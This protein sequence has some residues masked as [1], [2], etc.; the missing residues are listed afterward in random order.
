MAKSTV[1]KK[2]QKRKAKQK[3]VKTLNVQKTTREKGWL[4]LEDARYFCDTGDMD[5]AV[6]F[7]KRASSALPREEQVF[8]LMGYIGS[9]TGNTALELDAF[10][11]L[12]RIGKITDE[13]QIDRLFKLFP[14]ERYK[15]CCEQ[16]EQ[17]LETFPQLRIRNKKKIK[18]KIQALRESCRV[19]IAH[20]E[21]IKNK[22]TKAVVSKPPHQRTQ[23]LEKTRP[24]KKRD[25]KDKP[26]IPAESHQ[27][28]VP[29]VPITWKIEDHC[30]F[31]ALSDPL[32]A[33]PETYEMA[34]QSHG[35]RFV[36]SFE[37]LIC[38]SSLTAVK[39]YWY[40]EETAKKVLKQFRG[41][42]LLSDEV[43]LGKTIEALMILA[44]YIKRGMVKT[45]LIL[46]PNPLVSQWQQEM[47]SKF[48]MDVSSTD[49]PEFK[50]GSQNFWK[51][52]F[53]I[54]SINQAKSKK[55]VDL[56]TAREYDL[57]I[58][59]EAH[60]LKNR[61][62]LNWKLVNSLKK[63]FI[64]LLT[65]TPVENNLMELYNLITLLKPGQLETATAF[66]EKFMKRGDPTD[67]RNRVLL[68][69]L[70]GQV[71]IRNTR[72]VA[73][74]NIPPRFAQTIRIAPTK[75]EK[76]FYARLEDL[77]MSLNEK[78]AGRAKLI[79][80]NLLAQ[81]GSSPK[82][83]ELTL[84]RML[85][86][87]DYL[88]AHEQELRAVKNLCRTLLDTPK[89]KALLKIITV[90]REKIIVFAKYKGTIE[91]LVDFLDWNGISFSVFHG[92][93]NNQQKDDAIQAFKDKAQVLVTT[94]IGGEGR[95]LQFCSRMV[96]YDLP[97]N[98]MKIEQRI[99]RI[100]RIG[101]EKEVQI[102]NFCATGSIEDYIL[103]I[104][105]RKINMFEM[106]IGE[107]D[108]IIGRIRGEAEFSDRV[109]DIWMNST[110]EQDRK[111]S[112][113]NL[114]ASLKRAKTGYDK[115]REL[116]EKLFGDGYE[117]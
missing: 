75:T 29:D 17:V 6:K 53:I 94:E 15:E 11:G 14:L 24:L 101:Q 47:K 65:A 73:G 18:A 55:N 104:L 7:I 112:F 45:C 35:I 103:D 4:F 50:S 12:D 74:I 92:S 88:L 56:I 77:I 9:C 10:S 3:Q 98:P 67:P 46:T 109:L 78:K 89:N 41:R 72:A 83:V 37:T 85:E 2:K 36:E 32:P 96:N 40:Q 86:K 114:G 111:K 42:A 16:A 23:K 70:L 117:L 115:T 27:S 25:R 8:H 49:D 64:L 19:L 62:T 95:N 81:A 20:E 69:E 54:A 71:M 63:R 22:K 87:E 102:F 51:A 1:D 28:V 84:V 39:S 30:F 116:D 5:R 21:M 33:G 79:V 13:M 52:P 80:K 107:I 91:H 82:A 106:V 43:G 99:G 97:W 66:R 68:K 31:Q 61:S 44:E 76:E 108:M 26:E 113:A 48:H 110:T 57:I 34:L 60:H 38:L 58:V 59:D 100:H 105:D 93:L 90:D